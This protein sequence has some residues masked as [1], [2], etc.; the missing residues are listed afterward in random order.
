MRVLT[1]LRNDW[2]SPNTVSQPGHLHTPWL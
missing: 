2:K 1:H